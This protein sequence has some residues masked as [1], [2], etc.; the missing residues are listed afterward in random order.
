MTPTEEKEKH[1]RYLKHRSAA[2]CP[3]VKGRRVISRDFTPK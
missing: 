3:P 2:L 1:E